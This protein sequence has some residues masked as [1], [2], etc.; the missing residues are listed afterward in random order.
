MSIQDYIKA[1]RAVGPWTY[2]APLLGLD[3]RSLARREKGKARI[4][5]EAFAALQGLPPYWFTA[6]PPILDPDFVEMPGYPGYAVSRDGRCLGCRTK[7]PKKEY[8]YKQW[9]ALSPIK[10]TRGYWV[11]AMVREDGRHQFK[12]HQVVLRAFKGGPPFEGAEGRHLD[13]NKDNNHLD[14]LEW[15]TGK[16]NIADAIKNGK[17]A[18]RKG[19]KHPMAKLNEDDVAEIKRRRAAGETLKVIAKRF[20][21][22]DGMISLI[23]RGKSWSH[24]P[25]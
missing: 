12:L 22:T 5:P 7:D 2:V 17:R 11:V 19:I 20:N 14:N 13:D 16:E 18:D 10:G 6:P 8:P 25:L 4:T 23:C 9:E 15:G 1:R 3:P 24:I 21:V